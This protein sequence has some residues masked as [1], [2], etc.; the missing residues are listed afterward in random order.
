MKAREIEISLPHPALPGADWA[1]CFEA[2]SKD[3]N[4]HAEAAARQA[5]GRLPSWVAPLMV[6]RNLVVR[7]FGLKGDPDAA[8]H[9]SQRIGMFPIISNS[10]CEI[11][12]GF[13]DRH[14]DFRIVVSTRSQ[15]AGRTAVRLMTLVKRHNRFGRI[16]LAVIMPFHKLI[17][18][19]ALSRL[20]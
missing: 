20:R 19:T 7:P 17:V 10:A 16:Y 6:L 8:A 18:A 13:D 3:D 14:L 9:A 5:F 12:L 1:D 15:P 4:L 2:L 11:I